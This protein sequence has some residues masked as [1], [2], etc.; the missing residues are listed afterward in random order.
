M[1]L[2]KMP[3]TLWSLRIILALLSDIT[4]SDIVPFFL[5]VVNCVISLLAFNG[6]LINPMGTK[7]PCDNTQDDN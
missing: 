7:I 5:I 1:F 2:E 6:Y 4:D 3:N